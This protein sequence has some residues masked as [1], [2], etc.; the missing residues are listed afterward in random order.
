M[1]I[2]TNS[3]NPIATCTG[4]STWSTPVQSGSNW[5]ATVTCPTTEDANGTGAFSAAYSGGDATSSSQANLGQSYTL[6]PSTSFGAL[7]QTNQGGCSSCYF[8]ET[9]TPDTEGDAFVNGSLSGQLTIGTEDNVVVDG[10]INYYDCPSP[11][12]KGQSG[13][14]DFCPYNIGGTNDSLGLIANKYVE[15]NHPISKSAQNTLLPACGAEPGGPVRS[16]T[17][18]SGISIDAAMLAL[19]ESFVVNNHRYGSPEGLLNVYG[20]IQ[21][22]ARGPVGTFSNN[23][24]DSGYTKHY[25]WDPLL[26]YV[27][28]PSYLVPTTAP[29]TLTAD[30]RHRR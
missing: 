17:A 18:G 22:N 4:L 9:G 16:V 26:D 24:P 20:S 6:H 5:T 13:A 7:S 25:T 19:S 10:N 28:P 12:K 11:L 8:G 30:Q 15:I 2:T 21:Q 23:A 27:S 1:T 3:T 14:L 29:W